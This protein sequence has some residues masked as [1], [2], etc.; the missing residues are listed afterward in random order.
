MAFLTAE[1]RRELTGAGTKAGQ[2][3][4][5]RKNRIPFFIRADGWPV[6]TWEA[7]NGSLGSVPP[8]SAEPFKLR[9]ERVK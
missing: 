4:M 2:I 7:V 6:V 9:L 1:D 8:P 3:Q 5:L